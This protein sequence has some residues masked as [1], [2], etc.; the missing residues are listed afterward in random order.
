M[1]TRNVLIFFLLVFL[2]AV[3]S[4]ASGPVD[5][6]ADLP[7]AKIIQRAQEAADINKYNLALQYYEILLERYG[8]DDEYVAVGKY[9][10]AFIYYK[11]KKYSSARQGFTEL[12]DRYKEPGNKLPRH[13]KAL[14]EKML[15]R[16]SEL[17][18]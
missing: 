15:S 6:P 12:L 5:A 2:A 10:I 3:F 1:K 14:S 13:F 18:H 8:Y 4:C 9:E 7:A 17:G 16:L 11:Q